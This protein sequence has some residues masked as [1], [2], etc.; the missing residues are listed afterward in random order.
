MEETFPLAAFPNEP[1]TYVVCADDQILRPDWSRRIARERLGADL[2][3]LPGSHSPFLSRP[4]TLVD[5]LLA[6]AHQH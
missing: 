1:S 6:I 5:T 4:G 3:E 2:V